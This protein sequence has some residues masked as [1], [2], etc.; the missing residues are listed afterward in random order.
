MP[1]SSCRAP[2]D[3]GAKNLSRNP[4]Q[5]FEFMNMIDRDLVPKR[6]RP[7]AKT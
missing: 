4:R 3:V 6:S 2:E 5:L 1:L 7:T